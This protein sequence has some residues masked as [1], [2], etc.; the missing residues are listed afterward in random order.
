MSNRYTSAVALVL[1]IAYYAAFEAMS[2]N[3]ALYGI[4]SV[5][6]MNYALENGGEK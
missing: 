5:V 6:G 2:L 4:G 3:P 1:L